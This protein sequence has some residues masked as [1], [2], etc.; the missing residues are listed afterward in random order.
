[1]LVLSQLGGNYADSLCEWIRTASHTG[2]ML[3]ARA[4]AQRID[5]LREWFER[6]A[7][8]S[9]SRTIAI[10]IQIANRCALRMF[11]EFEPLRGALA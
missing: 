5:A 2:E 6:V 4:F 7:L 8:C 3:F 1:M 11:R 9:G 10:F